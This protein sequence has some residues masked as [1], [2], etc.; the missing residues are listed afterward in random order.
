MAYKM[1]G[2]P[3]RSAFTKKAGF[4]HTEGLHEDHHT[5]EEEEVVE[6][7]VE[8]K[9]T[10]IYQPQFI[11]VTRSP[12][13]KSKAIAYVRWFNENQRQLDEHGRLLSLSKQARKRRRK[14]ANYK[15]NIRV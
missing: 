1:K 9:G 4:K 10:K 11:Q 3:L 14:R 15:I 8:E 7:V 5:G 12:S 13:A 2:F 6:E